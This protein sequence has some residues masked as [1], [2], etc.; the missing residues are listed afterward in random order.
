MRQIL[1][2]KLLFLWDEH[3]KKCAGSIISTII[4][5]SI[6]AFYSPWSYQP[7]VQAVPVSWT[8]SGDGSSWSDGANWSLG[9]VP[10]GSSD[11]TIDANVTVNIAAA[12]TIN[13]L[14]LGGSL[15]P[16]LNFQFDGILSS[17]P[18]VIDEGNLTINSGATIQHADGTSSLVGTVYIDVQNGTATIAG[19]INASEKGFSGGDAGQ[20]GNGLS[21]GENETGGNGGGGGHGGSGGNGKSTNSLGGSTSGTTV[22]PTTAGSGGGGGTGSG[23]RGGDAGGIIRLNIKGNTTISGT[24]SA[25]GEDAPSFGG[26]TVRHCG[27]G[28]SGGSIFITTE[29][30]L[31]LNSS[32]VLSATGGNGGSCMFGLSSGGGGGGGGRIA[33]RYVNITQNGTLAV[34]LGAAGNGAVGGPGNAGSD[35]TTYAYQYQVPDQPSIQTP[36]SGATSTERT[37]TITS[38]TYSGD[39]THTS[40]DW[41]ISTA[42]DDFTGTNLVAYKYNDT[43]NKT[44]ITIN[45]TNFTFQNSLS[46]RTE[47]KPFTTYYIRVRYKN[48]AGNSEYSSGTHNFKTKLNTVP[49]TPILTDPSDPTSRTLTLEANAF[50]DND[51]DSHAMSDWQIATDSQF[52][53]IVASSMEDD[54]NLTSMSVNSSNFFF[55]NSL[56]GQTSLAANTTYYARVRYR[57]DEGGSS[58][59]SDTVSFTTGTNVSP[60]KPSITSPSN[61]STNIS[62]NPQITS[63]SFSDPD[64]TIHSA[65]SWQ[66]YDNQN[67]ASNNLVWAATDD[68]TNLT[69]ITVNSSTGTFQNTL[70]G[71]TKLLPG[72]AYY[73]RVIHSDASSADS[74]ASNTINFQTIDAPAN[75]TLT[76]QTHPSETETYSNSTPSFRVTSGSPTPNHYHY[77]INQNASPTLL[78]VEAGISDE[79]GTFDVANNTINASGTWYVHIV[80]HDSDHNPS[81]NFDSYTINYLAPQITESNPI[82]G[83]GTSSS[84]T[85]TIQTQQENKKLPIIEK[86]KILQEKIKENIEKKILNKTEKENE[87]SEDTEKRQIIVDQLS[88]KEL[89]TY[90]KKREELEKVKEPSE[91]LETV[92]IDTGEIKNK[93]NDEFVTRCEMAGILA[94]AFFVNELEKPEEKP[95]KDVPVNH[96]CAPAVTALKEAG[97]IKGYPDGSFRKEQDITRAEGYK[98]IFEV[99]SYFFN[100]EEGDLEYLSKKNLGQKVALTDETLLKNESKKTSTEIDKNAWFA[101]YFIFAEKNN[102]IPEGFDDGLNPN[103][104]ME[105]EEMEKLIASSIEFFQTNLDGET[106]ENIDTSDETETETE[107]GT[108]TTEVEETDP[109]EPS[110]EAIPSE[111]EKVNCE[112]VDSLDIKD[113]LNILRTTQITKIKKM[114]FIYDTLKNIGE[115]LTKQYNVTIK[116]DEK[117]QNKRLSLKV[118]ETTLKRALDVM[119]TKIPGIS[120]GIQKNT[121]FVAEKD[122]FKDFA[123][124]IKGEVLSC[125][126]TEIAKPYVAVCGNGI[127]LEENEECDDG[128]T[129]DGDGCSKSCEIEE[130]EETPPEINENNTP[131]DNIEDTNT[132][133]DTN[134]TDN[135]DSDE[136]NDNSIETNDNNE[137]NNDETN[138]EKPETTETPE[139]QT[140]QAETNEQ[141]STETE[142][143]EAIEQPSTE[144]TETITDENDQVIEE[145]VGGGTLPPITTD[146]PSYD[147]LI[148]NTIVALGGGSASL[149]KIVESIKTENAQ[150]E[151]TNET[152][153]T[154]VDQKISNGTLDTDQDGLSDAIENIIGSDE[155]KSDTDNDAILDADEFLIFNTDPLDAQSKIAFTDETEIVPQITNLLGSDIFTDSTPLLQ[156]FGKPNSII[157]LILINEESK[158]F[159]YEIKVGPDGK[160]LNELPELLDGKYKIR[161]GENTVKDFSIRTDIKISPPEILSLEGSIIDKNTMLVTTRRKPSIRGYADLRS[162]VITNWQSAVFASAFIA[163]ALDGSFIVTSPR[164]LETGNHTAWLY[165]IRPTDNVRSPEIKVNFNITEAKLSKNNNFIGL[166][167]LIVVIIF[168]TYMG[169]KYM[170]KSRKHNL[171]DHSHPNTSKKTK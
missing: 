111:S 103:E 83:G 104:K 169:I 40:S 152:N 59:Y 2:R 45:S 138:E 131:D 81:I 88:K 62:I 141:P 94:K 84:Q 137:N 25:D 38:S 19:N 7:I 93:K 17:T 1:T 15:S 98:I 149:E 150:H 121:L 77:L 9:N 135:N 105:I 157:T 67:I 65:S 155:K 96:P 26:S 22:S 3:R 165:S 109:G 123:K 91:I 49:A 48:S 140:K 71:R 47:L 127:E 106:L 28:G 132:P 134:T 162:V 114:T 92:G 41:E 14:T 43:G 142:Q 85:Q 73:I 87:K 75:P 100:L 158:E 4:A 107:V 63:S 54:L 112:N 101:K 160:F 36:V 56:A 57:D 102:L 50:S 108:E 156:G 64:D 32:A 58:N 37:Q 29:G 129:I 126:W 144:I 90:V 143:T 23:A 97:I 53:S 153:T 89:K 113:A 30:T 120:W 34:T 122:S 125:P 170:K 10:D 51:N 115:K 119:T 161:I 46:G 139:T 8:G 5:A 166:L 118:N 11:V 69:N 136:L 6:L 145:I 148:E 78:Q 20:D 60:N 18:L 13:S 68:P 95:F 44:Q 31:T 147:T 167:E 76:S 130:K 21:P 27:G 146:S 24:L 116:I 168:T 151:T 99:I 80:S 33:Y 128:N 133:D 70:S 52:N 61:G 164:D 171:H 16:V 86:I 66:I 79:D 163:D 55:Q 117:I 159:P 39:L 110:T 12:T 74:E 124:V 72:I 154:N 82:A 42:S 35:G